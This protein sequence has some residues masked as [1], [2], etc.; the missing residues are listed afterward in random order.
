[1][2]DQLWRKDSKKT[3]N[4][5]KKHKLHKLGFMSRMQGQ[6]R[7]GEAVLK[8]QRGKVDDIKPVSQLPS[9]FQETQMILMG[10]QRSGL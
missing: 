4:R 3:E 5:R 6:G 10:C 8:W 1:M 9:G 7:G 2:L